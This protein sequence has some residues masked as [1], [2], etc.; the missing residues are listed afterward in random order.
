LVGHLV[1]DLESLGPHIARARS[2]GFRLDLSLLGE[3]VLGAVVRADGDVGTA[4]I[5]DH[6]VVASARRE[7]LTVLREQTV[8]RTR[9]RFGHPHS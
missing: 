1:A 8:T 6:P 7:M 4:T 9:H 3:A 5:L 2:A